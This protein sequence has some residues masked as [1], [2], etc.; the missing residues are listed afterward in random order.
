MRTPPPPHLST[1]PVGAPAGTGTEPMPTRSPVILRAPARATRA[2]V[3]TRSRRRC[4]RRAFV[5]R[6]AASGNSLMPAAPKADYGLT[7]RRAPDR[8]VGLMRRE[9]TA[10]AALILLLT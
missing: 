6:R 10:S 8:L 7:A 2:T 3:R 1:Q 5:L 4:R 9:I